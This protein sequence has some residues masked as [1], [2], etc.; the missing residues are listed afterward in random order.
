MLA[1][2]GHLEISPHQFICKDDTRWYQ[3]HVRGLNRDVRFL[4]QP[5]RADEE[6]R[7]RPFVLVLLRR[8]MES[9]AGC[10]WG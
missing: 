4:I 6:L 5:H 9:I 2:F 10:L 7:Q 1:A 3:G 8:A